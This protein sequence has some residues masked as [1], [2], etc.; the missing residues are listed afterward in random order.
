MP[1][2]KGDYVT[3]AGTLSND[4][5]GQFVSA[6]TIIANVGVYTAPFTDPAY[7]AI[8]VLLQGTGGIPNPNIAQEAT[9]KVRVE[10]FSTDA[11]RP[12]DIT[13][14]DVDCNGNARDRDPYWILAQA[15]D[16]GPPTGAKKGRFR[17]VP[18]GGDF[19]P[20]TSLV[21]VRIS[22]ANGQN[23]KVANGL[24]WGQ[25][26]APDFDF[27]FPETLVVG[28]PITPN[29]FGD[30]PWLVNGIG[31]WGSD[32]SMVGQLDPWPD[33]SAPATT[34]TQN[35]PGTKLTADFKV[36][37]NPV[38]AGS[39]V[40]LDAG[41][42]LQSGAQ[43]FSWT[44]AITCT[45]AAC[46]AGTLTTPA[47]APAGNSMNITL[48]V[49][50]SGGATATST[51]ALTVNPPTVPRDSVTIT[52]A[53]YSISKSR[54]TVNATSSIAQA[55]PTNCSIT[56]P[57]PGCLILSTDQINKSTGKPWTAIMQNTGGGTY[58]VIL[59]GTPL[60]NIIT[61]VSGNGGQAT[62]GVTRIR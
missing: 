40:T 43:T 49:T 7:V 3:Y 20:P 47:V 33:V 9:A 62:S 19:L 8:D 52:S 37:P 14:I 18:P 50:G 13:A 57:Q 41:A 4:S 11:S 17:F 5:Q 22:G 51:V 38:T 48:N 53:V 32:G 24:I 45:N 54:L 39:K 31:P 6:H 21:H 60:P 16:P 29:N 2:A 34:C 28:G 12:L 36:S 55:S 23:Q 25:Y 35:P 59:T 15:V 30:F 61:V 42:A 56:A 1:F 58:T 46:S 10:G 26:V 44:P 27:V